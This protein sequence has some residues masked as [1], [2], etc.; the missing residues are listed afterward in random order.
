MLSID[1]KN[2]LSPE[3][4][5]AVITGAAA[6]VETVT[7]FT[8]VSASIMLAVCWVSG[9]FWGVITAASMLSLFLHLNLHEG[10]S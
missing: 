7:G 6:R 5:L 4:G 10:H 3:N 9:G 8:R 1:E 2:F